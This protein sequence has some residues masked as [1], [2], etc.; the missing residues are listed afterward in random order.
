MLASILN[1]EQE[2]AWLVASL[3]CLPPVVP[4]AR[5]TVIPLW[6]RM[7]IALELRDHSENVGQQGAPRLDCRRL[8]RLFRLRGGT[9]NLWA[10]P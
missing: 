2:L 5:A 8:P 3:G 7:Q 1:P 4:F 6:V 10:N 9:S